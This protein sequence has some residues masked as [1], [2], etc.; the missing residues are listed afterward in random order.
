MSV[1]KRA[2]T[3]RKGEVREAWIV[4]YCDAQGDRHIETFDRKKDADARHDAVRV[5]VR[6]GVHTA[7]SKSITIADAAEN[8]IKRVQLNNRERSTIAQ[9]RQHIDLHIN[10]RIGRAK[11]ASLTTP[12][13]NSFADELLA[14]LSR[15][16][17]RK[18]LTTVKSIFSDAQKRGDVSQNVVLPVKI[19]LEKRGKKR[20]KVGVDIPTPDE[21]KRILAGVTGR[22]RAIL[23]TDTFSGLRGSELRGLRW[24]NVDLKRAEIHVRERADRYGVMGKPKSES[25]ERTIPIGPM[26]VSTLREW[27]LACPPSGLDLVFPTSPGGIIHHK[28][29]IGQVRTSA[30]PSRRHRCDEM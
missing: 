17:A 19:G 4:D 21:M 13:M 25:G 11:L 5:D 7:T 27:K 8:W 2:W 22:N 12:R 30:D 20:L 3:T 28:N 1:R 24:P 18:V 9:Y 23:V 26:V 29:L 10:P 15:A 6:K 16:M 14:S